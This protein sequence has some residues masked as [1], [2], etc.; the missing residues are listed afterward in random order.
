MKRTNFAETAITQRMTDAQYIEHLQ[1]HIKEMDD[2]IDCFINTLDKVVFSEG[3]DKA[4]K[5]METYADNVSM[6]RY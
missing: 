4:Q 3:A 6:L 1:N 2:R 5:L